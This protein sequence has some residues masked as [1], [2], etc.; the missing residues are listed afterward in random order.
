MAGVEGSPPSFCHWQI[1]TQT[2]DPDFRQVKVV[3]RII[4]RIFTIFRRDLV[5]KNP[6]GAVSGQI[7]QSKGRGQALL[8]PP[9][10]ATS[11]RRKMRKGPHISPVVP[12]KEHYKSPCGMGR[13]CRAAGGDGRRY[14]RNEPRSP[15]E[16]VSGGDHKPK[17][18]TRL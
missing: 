11:G 2:R 7:A 4:Q 6:Y 17:Y 10:C 3:K 9:Y 16:G 18:R 5:Q 13:V 14:P 15:N 12:P 8:A 1:L